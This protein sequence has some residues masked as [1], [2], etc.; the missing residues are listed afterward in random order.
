MTGSY[1]ANDDIGADP[2]A[3]YGRVDGGSRPET[4]PLG[5]DLLICPAPGRTGGTRKKPAVRPACRVSSIPARRYVITFQAGPG[6]LIPIVHAAPPPDTFAAVGAPGSSGRPGRWHPPTS[7]RRVSTR[8]GD[9]AILNRG[10]AGDTD[11]PDDLAVRDDGNA[12]L[13]WRCSAE[14]KCA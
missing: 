12:T 6:G 14:R 1:E 7:L 11:G 13:Q 4:P 2:S 5:L 8:F 9:L 10:R 3:L